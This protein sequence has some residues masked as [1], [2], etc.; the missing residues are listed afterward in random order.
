MV[1]VCR[2]KY[3]AKIYMAIRLLLFLNATE[4]PE[5]YNC[6]SQRI[7]FVLLRYC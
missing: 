5:K 7:S 3:V 6:I 1:G 4:V 2:P